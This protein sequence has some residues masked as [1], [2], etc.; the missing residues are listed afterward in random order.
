MASEFHASAPAPVS[1]ASSTK[2]AVAPASPSQRDREAPPTSEPQGYFARAFSHAYDRAWATLKYLT[3]TEV[4]TY[5]FSV[6]ANAILSFFPFIVLI[7]TV[8]RRV[9]HSRAMYDVI[10]QMLRSYLPVSQDFIVRNLK[11]LVADRHGVQVASLAILLFTSTGVFLPLEVALNQVWGIKKNRNYLRNQ[12]ISFGLAFA[13]GALALISIAMTAG[14]QLAVQRLML[15]HSEN[16]IYRSAAWIVMKIFAIL[17]T[18]TIFFLIYWLLPNGKVKAKQ[19]LPAAIIAGVLL[20]GAKYIYI[21]CLPLLDFQDVY[22]PFSISV[23]LMFWA[24]I[25][26]LLLLGGAYLSAAEREAAE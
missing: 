4:H 9:F 18:I 15:G 10:E 11:A 21:A 26:G 20:E 23:T 13:C 7:M 8:V 3:R 12:L 14:N 16:F 19:V 22:G 24:F 2:P 5:A 17:A 6:A 25:S 1:P